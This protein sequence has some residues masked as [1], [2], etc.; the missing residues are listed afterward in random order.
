VVRRYPLCRWRAAGCVA[1]SASLSPLPK[2]NNFVMS[3]IESLLNPYLILLVD[4]QVSL[5]LGEMMPT[6]FRYLDNMPTE[7][8]PHYAHLLGFM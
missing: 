5:R 8:V 1:I 3:F 2:I 4:P 6:A 7:R